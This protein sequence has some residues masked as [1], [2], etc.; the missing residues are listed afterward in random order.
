PFR[1]LPKDPRDRPQ[2]DLLRKGLEELR[3][4]WRQVRSE[5]NIKRFLGAFF[6]YSAGVQTV[7]YLAATFA[8]KELHFPQGELIAVVLILQIVA[9]GGAWLFARVSEWRGNKFSLLVMLSIWAGICAVAY[10][11]TQS[12]Q[13]YVIAGGVG[14]VMGGIQSLSRSTYSKLLPENTPD[15]A[16]F[17]SFYD[18]L[19]K[20]AIVL[21]TF[22]FG[23]VDQLFGMRNS[24]LF[25]ALFFLIGI[26]VLSTVRIQH[27]REA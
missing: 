17:F 8:E 25:L 20:V 7:L 2:T 26:A 5:R 13:F 11:V 15:T 18:I 27:A 6:A 19:E 4:V 24:V 9:I 22:M 16:S 21:G 10:F 23:L 12:W 1:R 3:K 14:L